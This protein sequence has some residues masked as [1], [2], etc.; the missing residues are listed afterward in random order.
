VTAADRSTKDFT[1][2]VSVAGVSAKSITSYRFLSANNNDAELDVDVDAEIDGTTITAKVPF[3]T[4]LEA[5]VATFVHTGTSIEIGEVAQVTDVTKNDFS[6]EVNYTVT[7][8]DKTERVYRVIVTAEIDPRKEIT[9]YS[10]TREKNPV[11]TEDIQATTI[12]HQQREIAVTV[13]SGT[14]VTALVA[15]FTT[16]GASVNVGAVEQKSGETP[17]DF[18]GPV[19]YGVTAKDGKAHIYRVNVIRAPAPSSD[20]GHGEPDPR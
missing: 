11:L 16:T 13:P 2:T 4:D 1:V 9:A 17:N 12:D 7:A 5:L 8:A 3:D 6:T 19:D 15:T 20:V 14:D 10:F 18:T